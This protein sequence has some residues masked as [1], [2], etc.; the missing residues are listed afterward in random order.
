MLRTSIAAIPF[1][2]GI[3]LAW[4]NRAH[5]LLIFYFVLLGAF[6]A[7]IIVS[8]L[9]DT[10]D[11]L[12]VRCCSAVFF[13]LG[14]LAFFL[15]NPAFD[16]KRTN[17]YKSAAD[18][19]AWLEADCR[20][21]AEPSHRDAL[22]KMVSYGAQVCDGKQNEELGAAVVELAKGIY[23]S[24]SMTMMDAT[25]SAAKEQKPD[26]CMVAVRA[27]LSIC[28]NAFAALSA[29]DRNALLSHMRGKQG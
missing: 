9:T 10:M 29:K 13:L 18:G 23:L 20:T 7:F 12:F 2:A 6:L 26:H 5:T 16:P 27:A 25:I 21:I 11:N 14:I 22:K 24:P 3:Y 8:K 15:T 17:L 1:A 19:F 28:P 4:E